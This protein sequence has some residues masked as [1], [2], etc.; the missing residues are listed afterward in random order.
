[1]SSLFE[2]C[3]KKFNFTLFDTIAFRI[4]VI[5]IVVHICT[6]MHKIG[7]FKFLKKLS[8]VQIIS[9]DKT[10]TSKIMF[11]YKCSSGIH[12]KMRF[13]IRFLDVGYIKMAELHP[14]CDVTAKMT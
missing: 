3:S 10:W 8:I 12:Y 7:K 1:M 11:T 9:E 13:V 14:M 5:I 4:T 6:C 2:M